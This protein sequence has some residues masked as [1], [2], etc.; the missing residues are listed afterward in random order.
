MTRD[1]LNKEYHDYQDAARK[2]CEELPGVTLPNHPTVHVTADR[3][4]AF[5]D[6][7]IW[8]PKEKIDV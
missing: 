5:V 8:V 3:D 6:A 4:G 1:E 7:V 2:L